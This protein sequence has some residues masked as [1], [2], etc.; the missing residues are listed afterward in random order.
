MGPDQVAAALIGAV[1]GAIGYLLVGMWIQRSQVS[2]QARN[3]GRAV[4]FELAV[5]AINVQVALD[6]HVFEPLSRSTYDQLLP[7]LAASLPAED[8]LTI[9]RAYM[10]HAGYEQLRHD[11]AVPQQ[12]RSVVL[13]GLADV[14][15]NAIDVLRQRVFDREELARMAKAGDPV[16][17]LMEAARSSVE[18]GR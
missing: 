7:Q 3:A 6:H 18:L 12:A 2:L 10:A 8:L 14:Q 15:R 5:N 11:H 13:R 1:F 9:A 4:Y 17:T 16:T